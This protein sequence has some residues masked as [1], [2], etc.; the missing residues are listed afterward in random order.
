MALISLCT[1]ASWYA[2]LGVGGAGL[3][4]STLAAQ[5]N[6][7]AAI[8]SGLG[9]L[10]AGGVAKYLGVRCAMIAAS[11]S[12]TLF[13]GSF[14]LYAYCAE[15]IPVILTGALRGLG[16]ALTFVVQS[17]MM[18]QYPTVAQQ[19]RYLSTFFFISQ[20]SGIVGGLISLAFNS[21][22]VA[23][24]LGLTTYYSAMGLTALSVG[25]AVLLVPPHTL[26]RADDTP[27]AL[28]QFTG[29][30]K[31]VTR[32]VGSFCSPLLLFLA[33]YFLASRWYTAYQL[34][35]F[36]FNLLNIRTRAVSN[37][38]YATSSMAS[39][40]LLG[41]YLD[42]A[43][44]HSQRVRGLVVTGLIT[45]LVVG[46]YTGALVFQEQFL[47]TIGA[48]SETQLIDVTQ[49]VAA[50]PLIIYVIWGALD[51][52]VN[53]FPLWVLT[54]ATRQP[55]AV[56]HHLGYCMFY[57]SAGLAAAWV[58]D[59]ARVS[60]RDQNLVTLVVSLVGCGFIAVVVQRYL[61]S[62]TTDQAKRNNMEKA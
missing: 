58:L 1:N 15:P 9:G 51:S 46:S 50:A 30:S 17:V 27:V 23:R 11:A 45:G 43:K 57:Q 61:V 56:A 33:P 29:W 20:S 16:M 62:P 8:A 25:M 48:T 24:T 44:G 10:V 3:M 49:P 54:R 60:M 40:L 22:D 39:S 31:E 37:I 5:A 2:V 13:M 14:V 59:S 42:H 28:L 35:S 41:Y 19:G 47:A 6:L 38:L 32:S 12:Y 7:A 36:N 26:T 55:Q 21:S 34:N 4:D 53:S 52:V 18:M